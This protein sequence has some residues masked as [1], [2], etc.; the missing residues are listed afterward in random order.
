M[1]K[2]AAEKALEERDEQDY[3]SFCI[4]KEILNAVNYNPGRKQF[5]AI[6]DEFGVDGTSILDEAEDVV[7]QREAANNRFL[8]GMKEL[9]QLKV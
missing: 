6:M 5:I 3:Q 9:A 7:K 8:Q 1:E 2:N 4:L